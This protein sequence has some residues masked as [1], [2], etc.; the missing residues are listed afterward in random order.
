[1]ATTIQALTITT[2]AQSIVGVDNVEQFVTLHADGS[3]YVGGSN[4][5]SSNGIHIQN[6]ETLQLTILEACDLWAITS[7]GTNTLRVLKVRVE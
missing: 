2:T 7:T 4:V 6:G 3:V 5:T 1:M